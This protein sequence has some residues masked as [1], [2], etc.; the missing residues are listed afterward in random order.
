[1]KPGPIIL[2][3]R[4]A[5]TRF[6]QMVAGAAEL[7][8]VRRSTSVRHDM[9]FV[10]P[11]DDKPENGKQDG[12]VT[13]EILEKF[14]V[15]VILQNDTSL[16][17]KFG[18]LAFD[19]IHDVRSELFRAILGRRYHTGTSLIEYAGGQLLPLNPSYLWYQFDFQ[20]ASRL[21]DFPEEGYYDLE[22]SETED[23]LDEKLQPSQMDALQRIY[24]QYLLS[25]SEH[26]PYT[27]DVPRPDGYPDVVVPDMASM[28]TIEDDPNPGAFGRGFSSG[29]DFYRILNRRYDPK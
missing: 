3:I 26:V 22:G 15:V 5:G 19:A 1:M 25:P 8:T 14:A 2:R 21:A 6:G 18:F 12:S 28:I 16:G 9:A 4:A 23:G 13:Q 10:V 29:Y 11:L 20:Y 24:T 17:E 27:G 7:D